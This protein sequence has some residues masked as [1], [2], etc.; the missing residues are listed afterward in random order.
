MEMEIIKAIESNDVNKL[1]KIHKIYN[2]L[3]HSFSYNGTPSNIVDYIVDNIEKVTMLEKMYFNNE[4]DITNIIQ[5]VASRLFIRG[6][7]SYNYKEQLNEFFQIWNQ[8]LHFIS[9]NEIFL[10]SFDTCYYDFD[11]LFVSKLKF[12]QEN[13]FKLDHQ[14]SLGRSSLVAIFKSKKFLKTQDAVVLDF[15]KYVDSIG[16]DFNVVDGYGCGM[17]F[18]AIQ[19]KY[20]SE[21][22]DF[23]I[24]KTNFNELKRWDSIFVSNQ[25]HLSESFNEKLV[26][27][28]ILHFYPLLKDLHV[29]DINKTNLGIPIEYKNI[30]KMQTLDRAINETLGMCSKKIYRTVLNNILIDHGEYQILNYNIFGLLK[31]LNKIFVVNQEKINIDFICDII[32]NFK[33]KEINDFIFDDGNSWKSINIFLSEDDLNTLYSIFSK[34]SHRQ[35]K[36]IIENSVIENFLL[37]ELNVLLMIR[38]RSIVNYLDSVGFTEKNSF[39]KIYYMIKAI[40]SKKEQPIFNLN[41]CSFLDYNIVHLFPIKDGCFSIVIADTNHQLIDW[42]ILAHNCIGDGEYAVRAKN[43]ESLLLGAYFLDELIGTIEV[44][45]QKALQIKGY[46]L[47]KDK[48]NQII[49]ILKDKKII[50]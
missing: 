6:F 19:N 11:E 20:S 28:G 50:L 49:R 43:G 47:S 7:N 2:L 16:I 17:L 4:D 45:N 37:A 22:I 15:L 5:I 33:I 41:Q 32:D 3:Y 27:I 40:T 25:I 30:F 38:E 24:K 8:K 34:F 10:Y 26:E 1:L 42:G 14:G 9:L 12:L 21:I 23:I 39:D 48:E 31:I 44:K 35:F 13:G 36:F 29:N 46:C 18:Y